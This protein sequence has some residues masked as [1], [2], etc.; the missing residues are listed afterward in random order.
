MLTG[1]QVAFLGVRHKVAFSSLTQSSDSCRFIS[2][3]CVYYEALHFPTVVRGFLLAA[4]F[5]VLVGPHS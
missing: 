3:I 1:L 4:R 5:V 2:V